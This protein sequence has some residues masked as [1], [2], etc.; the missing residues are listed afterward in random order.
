MSRVTVVTD[1]AADLPAPVAGARGIRVVPLTVAFGDEQLLDGSEVSAEGF[2]VRM[3]GEEHLPTTAS[4]SP[5][6]LAA[7]YVEAR[8]RGADGVVSVHLS[9]RLSRTL[10]TARV[11]AASADLPVE[12]VDS[13]SVSAGQAL[14]VLAASDAAARGEEL[15]SVAAV[16]SR[17]AERLRMA[18]A[19]ET[20]EYLKR[21]GRVGALAATLSDLLRVRPVL[22]LDHGEPVLVTRARTR[23]RAIDE[24]LTR[25]G[26]PAEAAAIFHSGA[27]EIGDAAAALAER[28]GVE[29]LLGWIGAVTGTHLGPG[30]LAAAVLPSAR[31]DAEPRK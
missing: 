10:E 9:A 12:V 31:S 2:W 14:A 22:S 28:C 20:V 25:V 13:R 26:A 24:V 5:D 15:S 7:A 3:A 19:I 30:A 11:A 21:G 18:A 27:G 8:D 29:P 16:A 23:R 17:A 6:A 4:P 1:S